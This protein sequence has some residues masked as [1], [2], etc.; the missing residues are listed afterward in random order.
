[1]KPTVGLIGLGL[2]GGPMGRNLLKVGFPLVVWNRTKAKADELAP[3]GEKVEGPTRAGAGA[4]DVLTKI[5][6][7][8]A[9]LEDVL[10]GSDAGKNNDGA[11]EG[12]RKGSALID[13][14][15]VS[16]EL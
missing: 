3:G 15:T 2:M 13:S 7:D 11:M 6:S 10:Y 9:A 4:A 1:M 12:L 8:P 16:P 5:A 14:S